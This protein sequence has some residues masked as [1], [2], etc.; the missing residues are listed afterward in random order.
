MV[1]PA[2]PTAGVDI[3]RGYALNLRPLCRH[4]PRER[5]GRVTDIVVTI[6]V[7]DAPP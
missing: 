3:R 6:V 4:R 2:S 7:M 1:E 5:A